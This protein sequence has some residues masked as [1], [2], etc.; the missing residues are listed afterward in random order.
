[1][2]TTIIMG[3]VHDQPLWSTVTLSMI[4]FKTKWKDKTFDIGMKHCMKLLIQKLF[5]FLH[6][7]FLA[8]E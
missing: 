6:D 3:Y 5:L 7:I 2:N 8:A 4:Y 1:M